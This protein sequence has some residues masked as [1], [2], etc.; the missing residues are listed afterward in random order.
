M[1]SLI[2]PTANMFCTSATAIAQST[3]NMI[4]RQMLRLRGANLQ[5]SS[6]VGDCWDDDGN[7]EDGWVLLMTKKLQQEADRRRSTR[8]AASLPSQLRFTCP[9]CMDLL[10]MDEVFIGA[11][12]TPECGEI[13][14]DCMN[15]HV[16]SKISSQVCRV[17]TCLYVSF[18]S[19]Y[20]SV[21]RFLSSMH[22]RNLDRLI[23]MT[24]T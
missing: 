20:L 13:C 16:A 18:F 5:D 6:A 9:I 1:Q 10:P 15:A 2:G 7:D 22:L 12:C 21:S 17:R 3:I 23:W 8:R 14:R 19:L 4:G 24:H 11:D